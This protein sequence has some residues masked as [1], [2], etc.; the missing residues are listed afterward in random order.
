MNTK[1]MYPKMEALPFLII[2]ILVSIY[3]IFHGIYFV[4]LWSIILSFVYIY[5]G[6]RLILRRN[7]AKNYLLYEILT[8]EVGVSSIWS[9]PCVSKINCIQWYLF[10]MIITS[11]EI[12]VCWLIGFLENDIKHYSSLLTKDGFYNSKGQISNKKYLTILFT[13]IFIVFSNYIAFK[14]GI[15]NENASNLKL[16]VGQ[17]LIIILTLFSAIVIYEKIFLIIH[18]NK[19]EKKN[20]NIIK[21]LLT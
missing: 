20:G 7:I 14:I 12:I 6:R 13:L 1:F 19:L 16:I 5:I 8:I 11:I 17:S 10:L 21:T 3:L 15:I 9:I 18:L 4:M 2:S